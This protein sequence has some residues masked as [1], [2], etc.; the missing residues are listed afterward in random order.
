M[1]PTIIPE[2]YQ[3][4][5][6]EYISNFEALSS[7]QDRLAKLEK[8]LAWFRKQIFGT[9]SERLHPDPNQLAMG[10]L[11]GNG[12]EQEVAP[13]S[14][15]EP[16]APQIKRAKPGKK[17]L[18]K[19]LPRRRVVHMPP[20]VVGHEEAFEKIG[21]E[22]NE[23]LNF[24]PS[25]MEIIEHVYPKYKPRGG[26]NGKILQSPA[27]SRPILQGRPGSGL[28][29]H[30]LISKF[31][32]HLPLDRQ[33]KIFKRQKIDIPKSTMVHWIAKSYE[34]LHPICLEMKNQILSGGYVLSDD[35][36]IQVLDKNKPGTSHRGY[37]WTYGDLNQVVYDYTPGRSRD[38]PHDFLQNYSGFLQTDGYAAYND[39]PTG[40]KITRIGCWAHARRKFFELKDTE[41]EI[42]RV[43]LELIGN[44]FGIEK[45]FSDGSLDFEERKKTAGETQS[46]L[47]Q[48]LDET[49]RKILPASS[50]AAAIN[51]SLNQWD[52]LTVYQDHPNLKIDNNFSERCIKSVVI[53]RKNWLFAGSH[54]GARRT[55]TIYSLVESCKLQGHDPWQYLNDMLSRQDEKGL[56][57]KYLT[58]INW[59]SP[60]RV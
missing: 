59:K 36:P 48:W 25:R 47:K 8:E 21:E 28:L 56:K 9:K 41:P 1:A 27:V 37:L 29:A 54:E 43:P 23:E 40:G 33:V 7:T 51:Y 38:G 57:I 20:E 16:P 14:I 60:E 34:M 30:I 26:G 24:I 50:L 13:K 10:D 49:I 42:T 52:R 46:R 15:P 39:I 17:P 53:G 44:L 2:D 35:T 19:D 4:L 12:E 32:D 45:A 11:S 31:C 3:T 22:I 5:R 55:A 18:P 6:K 58:P